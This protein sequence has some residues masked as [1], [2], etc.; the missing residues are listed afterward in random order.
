MRRAIRKEQDFYAQVR[1]PKE[2]RDWQLATFNQLWAAISKNVPFYDALVRKG[3]VPSE[4]ESWE[5]FRNTLPVVDRR[6]VQQRGAELKDPTRPMDFVRTTGGSTSEPVQLPAWRSELDLANADVWWARS[7]FGIDPSD[8][9]FLI[10]GHRHL[11][12][13]GIKGLSNSYVRQLKDRLAGYYRFSAYDIRPSK[14]RGA[15]DIFLN[16]K[17]A[18]VIA[19]AGA[20]DRFARV[21]EGRAKEF[22]RLGLK[23]AIATTECFPRSDSREFISDVLGCPVAMEYGAIE[24]GPIAHERPNKMFQLF[25]RHYVIEGFESA[26]VPRNYDIYIT[27]LYPRAFPLIRYVIGDLISTDPNDASFNQQFLAIKGRSNEAIVLTN[28]STVHPQAFRDCISWSRSITNFQIV[29]KSAGDIELCFIATGPVPQ[30]D[31]AE[32]HRRLIRVNHGFEKLA[33][34]EVDSLIQTAAGK[35]RMIVKEEPRA[36]R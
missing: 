26:V 31:L 19:Y 8:K 21:N 30:A 9:L 24:T 25:W 1:T 28:G 34:R 16:F 5:E 10:W 13:K 20:L 36:T 15:G 7:W 12:G 23:A 6:L 27:S 33:F 32:I 11:L 29:Q 35:S 2:I 18:Y 4:F 14:L 22:H 3:K 17:P